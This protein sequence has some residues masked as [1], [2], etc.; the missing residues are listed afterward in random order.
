MQ[1]NSSL[2]DG[3]TRT[4]AV[5]VVVVVAGG[6]T[7]MEVVVDVGGEEWAVAGT[8]MVVVVAAAVA[9]RMAVVGVRVV[10][11]TIMSLVTTSRGGTATEAGVVALVVATLIT[12]I[13]VEVRREVAT[14]ILGGL[15]WAQTLSFLTILLGG[16]SVTRGEDIICGSHFVII[17]LT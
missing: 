9:T 1:I 14:P 13:K 3:L 12:T 8:R 10:G 4:S 16:V 7:R 5:V 15:S 11:T 17:E 6:V 2:L